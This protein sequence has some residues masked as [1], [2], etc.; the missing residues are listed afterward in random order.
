VCGKNNRAARRE[1][2]DIGIHTFSMILIE[3]SSTTTAEDS[4]CGRPCA[5][6]VH[7]GS[8]H[9]I[10]P[11]ASRLVVIDHSLSVPVID[12]PHSTLAEG[13]PGRGA[14]SEPDSTRTSLAPGASRRGC[15][16]R[17][18]LRCSSFEF[19]SSDHTAGGRPRHAASED[20]HRL[21]PPS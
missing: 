12:L 16:R 11:R 9:P 2:S 8:A 4:C 17:R 1:P 13:A 19:L 3:G 20:T 5:A 14:A 10:S 21:Q 6:N 7:A 18:S 15:V